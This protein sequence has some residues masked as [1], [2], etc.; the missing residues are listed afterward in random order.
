MIWLLFSRRR[1][2]EF[3]R[4]FLTPAKWWERLLAALASAVVF[5]IVGFIVRLFAAP[6]PLLPLEALFHVILLWSG[7]SALGGVILGMLFPKVMIC[8][9]Y[10]FSLL[11]IEVDKR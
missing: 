2:E 4:W 8:V 3:K 11:S 7:L 10:P 5:A 6:L 9:A 1:R